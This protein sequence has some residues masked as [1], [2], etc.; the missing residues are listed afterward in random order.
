MF[1]DW[2]VLNSPDVDKLIQNNGR[3]DV[4]DVTVMSREYES[5]SQMRE[6]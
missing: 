2:A 3:V 5:G 1:N 4:T 6:K